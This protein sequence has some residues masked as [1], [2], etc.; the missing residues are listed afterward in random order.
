MAEEVKQDKVKHYQGVKTQVSP[1]RYSRGRITEL[2]NEI[3]NEVGAEFY[4][5]SHIIIGVDG[6]YVVTPTSFGDK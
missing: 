2:V 3:C 4:T 1:N 6:R 5:V